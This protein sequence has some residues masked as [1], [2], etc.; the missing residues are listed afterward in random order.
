MFI[1]A[2]K[3][4]RPPR[5]SEDIGLKMFLLNIIPGLGTLLAANHAEDSDNKV[6]GIMQMCMMAL[7]LVPLIGGLLFLINWICAMYWGWLIFQTSK[8]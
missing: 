8:E 6:V 7:I 1:D 2:I 3:E 5:V 4:Q